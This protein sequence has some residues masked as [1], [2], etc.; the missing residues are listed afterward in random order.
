MAERRCLKYFPYRGVGNPL[1]PR[2]SYFPRRTE[3]GLSQNTAVF[4][5]TSGGAQWNAPYFQALN[6]GRGGQTVEA[7]AQQV[8]PCHG[9]IRNLYI[10]LQ[11]APG[12][13][14]TSQFTL[15]V[16]GVNTALLCT[17]SGLN[18]TCNNTVNEVAVVPGDLACWQRTTTAG[19]PASGDVVCSS[20]FVA[21]D[22]TRDFDMLMVASRSQMTAVARYL[23]IEGLEIDSGVEAGKISI[24]PFNGIIRT[25][26]AALDVPPGVG[27]TKTFMLRLNTVNTALTC[28]IAGLNTVGFDLVNEVAV[29]RGDFIDWLITGSAAS[30]LTKPKVSALYYPTLEEV[31]DTTKVHQRTPSEPANNTYLAINGRDTATVVEA[32]HQ[33]IVPDDGI[34][35]NVAAH[36]G[37][38]PGI[39]QWRRFTLRVNGVNTAL[40][41]TI[42]DVAFFGYETATEVPV[43]AGDLVC[44]L[45]TESA[46]PAGNPF[47]EI[48]VMFLPD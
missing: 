41:L 4:M 5:N 29:N 46:A 28:Q 47:P 13:G 39:G 20:L 21:D 34:I 43:N 14:A 26:Y 3:E 15:R 45:Y 16:N 31:I 24:I 2:L 27:E 10:E 42:A 23:A 36:F 40:I 37:V 18:L 9:V 17:I 33:M 38:A 30:A 44:W 48:S 11:V 19:G 7:E 32:N 8:I 1:S 6:H 35:K 25:L 22:K 12:V